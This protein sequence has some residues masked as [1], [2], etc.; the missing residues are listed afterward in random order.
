M[1]NR[2]NEYEAVPAGYEKEDNIL[3]KYGEWARDRRKWARCSSAEG[4]YKARWA[5]TKECPPELIADFRAIEVQRTILQL[6]EHYR[7]AIQ[8]WYVPAKSPFSARL[9]ANKLTKRKL[10][11]YRNEALKLFRELYTI[12][13]TSRTPCTRLVA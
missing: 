8:I 12:D 2:T 10:L 13:E 6:P 11:E 5:E 3:T 1:K 7:M 4:N 9:R